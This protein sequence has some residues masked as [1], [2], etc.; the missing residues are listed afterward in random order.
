MSFLL[1]SYQYACS[2]W[3]YM[4]FI[5]INTNALFVSFIFNGYFFWSQNFLL[6][7]EILVIYNVTWYVNRSYPICLFFHMRILYCTRTHPFVS[8]TCI[9]IFIARTGLKTRTK[10]TVNGST[11]SSIMHQL[12]KYKVFKAIHTKQDV[13]LF[14]LIWKNK[15]HGNFVW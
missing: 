8:F 15:N 4:L 13:S 14:P 2:M 10:F 6:T 9:G 3:L 7:G 5:C 11:K 1:M 12:L